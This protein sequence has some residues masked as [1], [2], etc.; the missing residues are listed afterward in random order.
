M[1]ALAFCNN[2]IA[3]V[4]WTFD[5]HLN[6]CLGFAVYQRDVAAGSE[7]LLPALARFASQDVHASLTTADAPVQKFWW[8]DLYAKRGRTYSYRIVPLGGKPSALIP[9]EG[10]EP[11][12][13]NEV[14]LTPDRP[15]FKAY[16]NR[17]I[18]ASQ[19]VI[20][21]LGDKADINILRAHI[22]DPNDPLR[23]RLMGQ[24]FD[25]V[26]CLLDRADKDGGKVNAALYELDDPK[27][28][29]LRLQA[30]DH[31]DAKSR[32]VILGNENVVDPRT[33]EEL[34]DA[35]AENRADLKKAGV[36]V[37]DRIL[38][39]GDIPHNKFMVLNQGGTP[40][41]TLTGSTNWTS[42]GLCTQT[43][44]TLVIE[45]K[46]IA[47][48]Y[49]AYWDALKAD[50]DAAGG[51]QKKLQGAAL[52]A[53]NAKNN[54]A[55]TASPI[56]LEDGKTKVEPLFS[57]NTKST[58]KSPPKETPG[59][60][61]QVFTLVK[62]AKQAILFLAFD[63]GNNSI[64]DA[65]GA[66]LANNPDLFV[67]G[68]LTSTQRAANFREALHRNDESDH[69]DGTDMHVAVIGEPG[70]PKAKGT[71][72]KVQPDY[73]AIPAGS[74]NKNDAFGP[75]EAELYKYGHAIIHDKVVVID[76]FSEECIVITGS[77]NLGYRASHNNDE[78]MLIVHGHRGLA[79]A[80]ACHVLDVYDH[81]AWRYWLARFPDQFGKPL[82][83]DDSW[84]E[85]YLRGDDAKSPELR[86]W[87]SA[88]AGGVNA[89]APGATSTPKPSVK[90]TGGRTAIKRA[91]SDKQ[92]LARKVRKKT[93]GTK[94]TKNP[95]TKAA[96]PK[97]RHRTREA[98]RLS[99][100]TRKKEGRKTR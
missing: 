84:Q 38:R 35:D 8:K 15:P 66:A 36:S 91:A 13:S 44:N 30:A 45:S 98:G 94:R 20:H 92:A 88:A 61:K 17:G 25:G 80:Y 2:D 39:K 86:F 43:N 41:A 5:K 65:A 21:A 87:L 78:N 67:R 51:D 77:H 74:V 9:L 18:I 49:L 73:R 71:K 63:P 56:R 83:E 55:S 60:M 14:L 6:G 96:G 11:L 62:G 58:L 3:V 69:G 70:K 42:S 76:P 26:T 48:R 64:L 10:I 37:I 90:K 22:T 40:V 29:E 72:E 46:L 50:V 95:H 89:S 4:A 93:A 23:A 31:G 16:F 54:A 79:E 7:L 34:E 27:G 81:Y 1:P 24:L 12:V 53:S 28:L 59:D 99:K 75:W 85:R 52:R 82:E 19:A 57:P 33:G 97:T 47:Q 32:Q 68:A 100:R